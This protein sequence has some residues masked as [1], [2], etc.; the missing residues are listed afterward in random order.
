MA[1]L[2]SDAAPGSAWGP[3]TIERRLGRGPSGTVYL[4]KEIASGRAVTLKIFHPTLSA[5]VLDRF[6]TDARRLA[7][8]KHPSILG[9]ESFGRHGEA[10]YLVSEAFEGRNLR[11][12]G[13][14][15]PREAAELVLQA[16][17][18]LAAGW[19]RLALHRNLKPE[20]VLVGPEG[21]VCLSDFGFF[22]ESTPYWSPERRQGRTAD[23]RGDLYSLGMLFKELL[24]D[25]APV[26]D[27]LVA[28]LTRPEAVERIQ[29]IEYLIARLESFLTTPA[30]P[31]GGHGPSADGPLRIGDHQ[32]G[33][34]FQFRAQPVAGGAGAVG[35]VEGEDPGLQLLQGDQAV[36]A[37]QLL[38]E[39]GIGPTPG[40]FA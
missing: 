12:L 4:A 8:F 9:V 39:D 14:K 23:L 10:R 2:M 40:L 19:G 30:A 26:L 25:G 18:G 31:P 7:G 5:A 17:R 11:D 29:M 32:L 6:E 34:E 16:A 28:H 36:G 13:S 3:F 24:R 33:V 37:A 21:R 27:E 35:G 1:A 20:N 22:L 38:G 15:P